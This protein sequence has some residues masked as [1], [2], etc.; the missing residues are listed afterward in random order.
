MMSLVSAY[1]PSVTVLFFPP[2]TLPERS[3]G[4]PML[5]SFPFFS[6]SLNQA[7]HFCIDCCASCGLSVLMSVS[8]RYRKTYSL[9]SD[10]LENIVRSPYERSRMADPDIFFKRGRALL[11]GVARRRGAH[12]VHGAREAPR[13]R[14]RPD[15]AWPGP[16]LRSTRRR[17]PRFPLEGEP[18]RRPYRNTGRSSDAGSG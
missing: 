11:R 17:R 16:W 14:R 7:I 6:S 13:I 8:P 5:F 9:I 15:H 18:G 10:L 1:G 12:R 4:C 2:T 3:R